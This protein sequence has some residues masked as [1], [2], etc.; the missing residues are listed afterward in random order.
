MAI[1]FSGS[2]FVGTLA[3]IIGFKCG[4]A[5]NYEEVI[6]ILCK[7]GY[8]K[9][10][11]LR[12]ESWVRLHSSEF[13]EIAEA[14]M[15][16]FGRLEKGYSPFPAVSMYH[17]YKNDP[18]RINIFYAVAEAYTEYMRLYINTEMKSGSKTLNPESLLY[19][20]FKD[21]G[22]LGL[23]MMMELL[24]K[25]NAAVNGSV[26]SRV[27][28]IEFHNEIELK[29]LFQSEGLNS[30]YGNFF[31][32][33]YIDYLNANFE[34]IDVMHWRKFEQMTAQFLETQGYKVELGPG[35]NDDGVDVR[36]WCLDALDKP[37]H[38]I[39]QCKRQKTSVDKVVVK[40]L[41]ADVVH[42]GATSGLLVTTSQLAPG[43]EQTRSARSYPVGVADRATLKKWLGEL[44]KPGLG[45]AR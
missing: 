22:E 4:V 23:E 11:N 21:H 1:N 41:F 3:D 16:S 13:Q 39:V 2:S 10:K 25:V 18:V 40:A 19:A 28:E 38:L 26:W 34:D 8:D 43:A 30:F 12:E 36:A 32:Q 14:L 24:E 42:E 27:R 7:N 31:D 45:D 35:R 37:P 17:K 15:R 44:R 6:G 29:D 20:I 33:R 5:V 9:F